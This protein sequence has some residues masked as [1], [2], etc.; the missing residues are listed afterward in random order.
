LNVI[1]GTPGQVVPPKVFT[2]ISASNIT[3]AFTSFS[4]A[5][6][7]SFLYSTTNSNGLYTVTVSAVP[8]PMSLGAIAGI[9]ATTML[10]RRRLR[11][12]AANRMSA[13]S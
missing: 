9:A 10:K 8:E 1:G 6:G 3:G 2:I 7:G 11:P 5:S 13:I 4:P 12:S